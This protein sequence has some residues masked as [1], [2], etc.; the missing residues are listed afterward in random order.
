VDYKVEQM[1]GFLQNLTHPA[2]PDNQGGRLRLNLN[3][4]NIN[5]INS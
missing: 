2:T 5:K 1:W 4:E 3:K